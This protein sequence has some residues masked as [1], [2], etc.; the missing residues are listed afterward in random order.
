MATCLAA[1]PAP[2]NLPCSQFA[3]MA[4][5]L[6][7]LRLARFFPDPINWHAPC[8]VENVTIGIPVHNNRISPLLDTATQLLVLTCQDGRESGRRQIPLEPQSVAALA[9]QLAA[10]QLDYLL[11]SA[12]SEPQLRA[13]Q[14]QNIP[15]RP[16]LCGEI[17]AILR[18]LCRGELGHEQFR[19]PGCHQSHPAPTNPRPANHLE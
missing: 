11:C 18:A 2:G 9:Q 15:V 14:Q 1:R 3:N 16:H 5:S 6:R 17:S 4:F 12:V 19:M 10:L 8:L 13:L 7:N